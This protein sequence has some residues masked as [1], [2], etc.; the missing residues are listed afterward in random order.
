[1]PLYAVQVETRKER[2]ACSNMQTLLANSSHERCRES[3]CIVPYT[4]IFKRIQKVWQK[5]INPLFPGY[6]LV[7]TK[8]PEQCE[9]IIRTAP[10]FLK[11]ITVGGKYTPLAPHETERIGIWIGQKDYLLRMSR[12][13][14]E[15]GGKALVIEGPLRGHE[16]LIVKVNRHKRLAFLEMSFL[17]RPTVIKVG[18]EIVSGV[19]EQQQRPLP[20]GGKASILFD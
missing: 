2:R 19:A 4:E 6:V 20:S 9:S 17:G 3:K 11:F 13:V 10:E 5:E 16:G 12:G 14:L 7:D 8:T 18:L 1:M 15:E